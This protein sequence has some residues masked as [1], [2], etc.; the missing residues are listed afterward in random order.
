MSASD[1]TLE[2]YSRCRSFAQNESNEF[3]ENSLCEPTVDTKAKSI[4]RHGQNPTKREMRKGPFC[5]SVYKDAREESN[6]DEITNPL[7][8]TY[9][10]AREPKSGTVGQKRAPIRAK[11]GRKKKEI[12]TLFE[13]RQISSLG[14]GH[15]K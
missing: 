9:Y 13:Q 7:G 3:D 5:Q 6:F 12:K 10:R 15:A 11:R 8:G 2:S 1:L 4:T 14:R